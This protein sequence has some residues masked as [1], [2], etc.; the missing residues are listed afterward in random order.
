MSNHTSKTS[1]SSARVAQGTLT[2]Q[3]QEKVLAKFN[4][5][6]DNSS[7]CNWMVL[8]YKPK[9]NDV[10]LESFGDGGIEELKDELS[11]SKVHYVILRYEFLNRRKILYIVWVGEGNF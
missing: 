7:P 5:I 11:D 1:E 9:S 8:S 6:S 2:I 10:Y 4:E 3:D